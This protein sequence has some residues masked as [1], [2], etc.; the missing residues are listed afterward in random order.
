MHRIEIKSH[1]GRPDIDAVSSLLS[2]AAAVDAHAPIDEHAWLDLVQGGRSGFAGLVAWADGHPHPVGYAQVTQGHESWALEYVVD[3]HHRTPDHAIASDLVAAAAGVIADA[4]GGHVHMWVNQPRPEHDRVA[5]RIGLAPG[6]ILYQMRRPLPYDLDS[7]DPDFAT[8]P[9]RVGADEQAWLEV[10]NRA[11]AWH[12]EQGGWDVGTLKQ[13]EGEPWFDPEGFL[14]HE[15]AAG[16]VDGFCWTKVHA[17]HDPPLGEIYVI[18]VDP[19]AKRERGLG[20]R[21]VVAGLDHLYRAGL[22]VGMLYVDAGNTSAV[23][24]YV[25]MGFVVN[26][27]DQAYVG[28]IPAAPAP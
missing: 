7:P 24:L 19:E 18:A 1:L 14:L 2:E 15:N 21:L 6:R 27:L 4:G 12:P 25:D 5:A 10:N 17:D 23:K 8:R 3:P 20:R 16:V 22:S 11:F 26:H 13:R 28:D 9:F